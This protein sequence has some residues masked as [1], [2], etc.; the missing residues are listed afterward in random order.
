MC[1]LMC[2]YV[3]MHVCVLC[4]Y[5]MHV[6]MACMY[7]CYAYMC[8]CMSVMSV[9]HVRPQP[10]GPQTVD[11]TALHKSRCLGSF[12]RQGVIVFLSGVRRMATA[13]RSAPGAAPDSA[14]S[15]RTAPFMRVAY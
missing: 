8:V 14:C 12:C 5:V 4:M 3:D 2:V 1:V 9:M 7:V 13:R 15:L 10:V 6:C 11:P